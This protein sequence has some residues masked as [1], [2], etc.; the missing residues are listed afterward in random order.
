MPGVKK[1]PAYNL[2][3]LIVLQ[4]KLFVVSKL[5]LLFLLNIGEC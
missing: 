4:N 2:R 3:F 5:F 1:H